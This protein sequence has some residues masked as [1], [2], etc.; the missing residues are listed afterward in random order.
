MELPA[1][2]D[3]AWYWLLPVVTTRLGYV[4]AQLI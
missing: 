3:V 2:R 1:T 4:L